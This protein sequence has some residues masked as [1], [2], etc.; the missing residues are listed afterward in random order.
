MAP[1]EVFGWFRPSTVVVDGM[2]VY[3]VDAERRAIPV[4]RER[5]A[6]NYGLRDALRRGPLGAVFLRLRFAEDAMQAEPLSVV[7]SQGGAGER[8]VR[9][10]A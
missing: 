2:S 3:L 8:S 9:L 7:Q 1:P 5:R 6:L 4:D 10:T